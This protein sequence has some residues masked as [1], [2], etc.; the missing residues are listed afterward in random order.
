MIEVLLGALYEQETEGILRPIRSDLVPVT[1][2]SRDVAEG[3][4]DTMNDKLE[5]IG[6]VPL[7]GAV[8]TPAG[9]LSADFVIDAVVSVPDEPETPASVQKALKNS[10]RRAADLG[11]ESLALPPLGT[12]IGQ[13]DVAKK[14]AGDAGDAVLPP[15][16]GPAPPRREDR[17]RLRVGA[18]RVRAA[19]GR[20]DE[21]AH[22]SRVIGKGPAGLYSC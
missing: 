13:L 3:A 9:G 5:H 6:A 17:H 22:G 8:I 2:A 1:S 11:L 10:L 12:G 7:G 20:D 18:A 21:P 15:G 16:R 19:R 4:G 14:C